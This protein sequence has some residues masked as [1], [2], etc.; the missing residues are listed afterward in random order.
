MKYLILLARILFSAI[1]F[2]SAFSH[3]SA[4]TIAYAASQGVPFPAFLVP[5]SGILALAGAISIIIGFKARLGALA[6]ILFLV[7]V[8]V[9]MHN[10]WAVSDP[11]M[12]QMQMIMFMKNLSMLGGAILIA[13]FGAGPLSFDGNN[14]C[15]CDKKEEA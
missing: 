3:F 15:C 13:Y 4:G 1:F 5:A 10:F 9:M 14:D 11:M 8:T 2:M 12:H 6:I 7:P